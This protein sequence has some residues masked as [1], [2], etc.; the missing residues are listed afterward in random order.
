MIKKILFA[1][2][3]FIFSYT[4]FIAPAQAGT[5]V[6]KYNKT[7]S[8]TEKQAICKQLQK[9]SQ[10]TSEERNGLGGGVIPD[11]VL[12]SLY[13]TTRNISNTILLV[14]V[15]G[16]SLM[17]HAVH[18]AKNE[19][20]IF[21]VTL[22]SYPN[23][24]IWICGAIIYFCGFMLVLS[25]TF[26]V[27]DVSFKL[28]FAIIL[29][30]IGV[31]LWPFEKTK[32]KIVM[33]ISIFL[34]SAAIL[35][36]LS[37]TVSYTIGILSQALGDL[38]EIFEAIS[39]NDTDY[40]AHRFTV[41]TTSF[42]LIVV[43][44]IYGMKL[45]SSTIPNYVDKFF[46]DKA[47][48]S[49][50][51]MHHLATQAMDFAKKK[52]V[53]PVAKYAADV[54][55]TQV[56]KGVEK[57]GKFLRFGYHNEVKNG[58]KNI[59]RAVRN[60]KQTAQKMKLSIKNQNAKFVGGAKKKYNNVK[61]GLQ[62]A[63]AGVIPK[64]GREDIRDRIRNT[65]DEK[66]SH[67]DAKINEKYTAARAD[68]DNTINEREQDRINEK[69]RIHEEKMRTDPA[70][71]AK[72]EQKEEKKRIREERREKRRKLRYFRI[73]ELNRQLSDIEKDKKAH[74]LNTEKFYNSA[75]EITDKV[76]QGKLTSRFI[77]FVR[78][79]ADDAYT[80]I[81]TGK[82]A[83]K[84]GDNLFQ[85]GYKSTVRGLEKAGVSTL[86]G[87]TQAIPL[88][89]SGIE[90]LAINTV[91][92][93]VILPVGSVMETANIAVAARYNLKKI[94]PGLK[95]AW[96]KVPDTAFNLVKTPGTILEKTGRAMQ[97]HDR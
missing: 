26:Y 7:L 47:F 62:I 14:S 81:N 92:W 35:A 33:L 78:K 42:L 58:I 93:G 77:R 29:M 43:A 17:C 91:K 87:L 72:F 84:E 18:A 8:K 96:Y 44:L 2:F 45:I 3:M 38:Q 12:T 32:D 48:G 4:A 88:T 51:P 27:V 28:G 54:A 94:S 11:E 40:V 24:P 6:S 68:I 46:P 95:K 69:Q 19:I 9:T 70:Y 13:N 34:K 63:A 31:A 5:Y 83:K 41:T 30:P 65:R 57:T 56:G 52:V 75:Q 97:N 86:S 73:G 53:A 90:N 61:Y 49:A 74:Q 23:I 21:G 64:K 80:N 71:R 20:K 10:P 1:V 39:Q 89:V 36:F 16:D 67:I 50:S 66:N 76:K 79:Q 15:L 59:G 25:I 60:P 55:E 37:I 82:Y 85:R 22:A